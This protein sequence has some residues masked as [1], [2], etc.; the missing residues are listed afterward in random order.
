MRQKRDIPSLQTLCIRCITPKTCL[1]L[2]SSSTSPKKQET[3]K[4]LLN[5]LSKRPSKPYTIP[6]QI[7]SN[8]IDVTSPWITVVNNSTE[9]DRSKKQNNKLI[10][11]NSNGALDVL[12]ILLDTF[13]DIGQADNKQLITTDFF[14]HWI[15]KSNFFCRGGGPPPQKN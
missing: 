7:G 6:K 3:I 10:I 2:T 15:K 12:Q 11:E 14:N 4:S 5:A 8:Q 9:N 1:S 13:V